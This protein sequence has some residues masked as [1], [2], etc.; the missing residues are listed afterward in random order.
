MEG[1]LALKGIAAVYPSGARR[2]VKAVDGVSLTIL[3]RET[4][5]LVGESG[6]GKTTL[7][8]IIAG[9]ERPCSGSLHF[10]GERVDPG[11]R[12]EIQMVFQ[13]SAAALNPRLNVADLV[14]EGLVI[15][16]K[17]D[18]AERMQH[19]SRILYDVGLD[20]KMLKRY[21][22]QLSGGQ[23]QRVALARTL[24]VLPSVIVLDEPVSALDVTASARLLLL[25][26]R[27]KETYGLSYLFIS[28]NLAVV[29][30][31]CERVAVMYLG[32]IVETGRVETVF[33]FPAHP[34]TRLL[35]DA[36]PHPDPK[37]KMPF[38]QLTESENLLSTTLGCRFHPRCPE[39][40]FRC[41][42]VAP[43]LAQKNEG[44][45]VACHNT[46]ESVL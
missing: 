35:L 33:N 20:K 22:H 18:R 25:L 8:K 41:R 16:K 21:P 5:G 3:G 45:F 4:F 14:E 30:Q 11:I 7:G 1:I 43:V 23:R 32:K 24:V 29:L 34:Y 15:Q 39:A 19:V 26:A 38:F 13:D 36:H 40:S 12:R 10:K 44:H 27:L 31:I 46:K 9:L 2:F 17:G 28:H 37:K 42:R 6:S